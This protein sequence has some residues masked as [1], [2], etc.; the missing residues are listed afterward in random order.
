MPISAMP[1]REIRPEFDRFQR[2]AERPG[3]L[4]AVA[5]DHQQ[6]RTPASPASRSRKRFERVGRGEVAH[7]QMRHRLEPGRAH[8]AA[9]ATTSSCGRVGTA[10]R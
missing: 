10:L 9:C 1:L 3:R 7:R 6:R 4:G 5:R 8:G 2:A